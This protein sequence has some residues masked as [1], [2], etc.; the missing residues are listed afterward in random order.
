MAGLET[1]DER[2]K[3]PGQVG[4][5]A[6]IFT[7]TNLLTRFGRRRRG[8]GS[9][10]TGSKLNQHPFSGILAPSILNWRRF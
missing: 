7:E 1:D 2:K 4:L 6:G 9:L 3:A 8:R 5:T 10:Y